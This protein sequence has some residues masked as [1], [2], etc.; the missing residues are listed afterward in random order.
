[1]SGGSA[2]HGVVRFAARVAVGR[3]VCVDHK[4]AGVGVQHVAGHADRLVSHIL[5]NRIQLRSCAGQYCTLFEYNLANR[6]G[7]VVVPGDNCY[8]ASAADRLGIREIAGIDRVALLLRRADSACDS[9]EVLAKAHSAYVDVEAAEAIAKNAS[10]V[11]HV[12]TPLLVPI[13]V[14]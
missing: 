6:L 2:L 8:A 7:H 3:R 11:G 1:M 12:Q 14:L 4:L 13:S 9:F 5:E 10:S